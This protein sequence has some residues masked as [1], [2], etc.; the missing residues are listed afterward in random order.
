MRDYEK[1][2]KPSQFFLSLLS[3]SIVDQLIIA[4]LKSTIHLP[5]PVRSIID[6]FSTIDQTSSASFLWSPTLD[7]FMESHLH[8]SQIRRLVKD[9]V[10]LEYMSQ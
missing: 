3:S 8:P 6:T 4:L 7:Y 10:S 2:G 1:Q 5:T 9:V